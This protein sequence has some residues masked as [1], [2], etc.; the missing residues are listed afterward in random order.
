[1]YIY[2]ADK[3]KRPRLREKK[4][5]CFSLP[6]QKL[7]ESYI[8]SSDKSSL[9]GIL[10][11]LYT[12]LRLGELLALE[13]T[14]IDIE[15]AELTINKTCYDGKNESGIFKRITY[16]PKTTSSIR[17]IPIPKQLLP[18]LKQEKRK[19]V[20]DHVISNGIKEIS[21]RSYQKAFDTTLKKLNIPHRGFHSLRHTFATRALEQGMDVKTLSEILGHKNS[22]VT[23]N[24][25]AHS[26]TEHKK[27]MMDRVGELL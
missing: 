24:R 26:F 13:W 18:L 20:S 22:T 7:I 3:I 15:K 12:G 11:C 25:Y 16:T 14:D 6:E 1:M 17:L 5:E 19:S 8:L 10:I 2:T 21:Y 27:E 4:T 9:L 23:L